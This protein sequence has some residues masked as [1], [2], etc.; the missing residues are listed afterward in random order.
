MLPGIVL[1]F[2]WHHASPLSRFMSRLEDAFGGLAVRQQ[3]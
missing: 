1:D 2:L 3:T